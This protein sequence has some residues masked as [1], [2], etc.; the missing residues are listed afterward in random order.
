MNFLQIRAFH[1]T[2]QEGG[3]GRAA[4]AMN[5]SQ[6]TISQHIKDLEARSN[7]KL[8]QR[9]GNRL[10]LTDAGRE[11]LAVTSKLMTVSADIDRMLDRRQFPATG[12]LSL[13]SDSPRLAAQVTREML[14]QRPDMNITLRLATMPEITSGVENGTIDAGI[15]VDPPLGDA[16][17]LI[18]PI[19]S[20]HLCAALAV[21][22]PLAE[23]KR[24]SLAQ[25]ARERLVFR[26][27][28]SRTRA[29]AERA[30]AFENLVPLRVMDFGSREIIREA[31][32]QGI[33]VAIFS[34]LDCMPDPRIRY[35][36][37]D[38]GKMK[39]SFVE[40]AIV[41]RDRKHLPE[42]ALFL[43]SIK[44]MSQTPKV[45]ETPA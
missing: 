20:D 31:V 22:H 8:F 44:T 3:V 27:K 16:T 28:S 14:D 29:L 6:P 10:V 7:V 12:K 26:D 17:L 11:L 33:G 38:V 36:R 15:S 13:A 24:I 42:V 34:A 32:A 19:R 41:R 39:L 37:I 43:D 21:G 25:L 45:D 5:V 18:T 30:M 40:H 9:V 1:M 2:V 23:A 35:L 4:A